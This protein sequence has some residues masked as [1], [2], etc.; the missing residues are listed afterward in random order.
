MIKNKGI[1]LLESHSDF[2]FP[3]CGKQY[4]YWQPIK[5]HPTLKSYSI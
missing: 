1:I 2:F 5:I 3:A 4:K